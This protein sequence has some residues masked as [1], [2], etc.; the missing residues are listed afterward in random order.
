MSKVSGELRALL[1]ELNQWRK[2]K[3]KG[4]RVPERFWERA[5]PLAQQLGAT[6]VC[7][8][9]R[10]STEQLEKRLQ[11]DATKPGPAA[12]V[13]MLSFV[14]PTPLKAPHE[15]RVCKG[16]TIKVEAASGARMQ[17]EVA[18]VEAA[19]LATILKEFAR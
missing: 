5:V 17:V 1:E 16:C 3:Q 8:E 15:D 11:P 19:G 4:G 7:R 12:F 13:E 14:G 6:N 2:G 9:L 18:Q 10:L